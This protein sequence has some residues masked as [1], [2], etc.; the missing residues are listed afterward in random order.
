[1]RRLLGECA[2]GSLPRDWKDEPDVGAALV[3]VGGAGT[4]AMGV[5][6]CFDDREPESRTAARAC[7]VGATEALEGVRQETGRKAI[8]VV[9]DVHLDAAVLLSAGDLDGPVPVPE[10][11]VDEVGERLLDPNGVELRL[12]L[13]WGESH[14]APPLVVSARFETPCNPLEQRP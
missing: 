14:D 12:Q 2:K 6:D 9:G 8:A 11:V 4:T 5:G 3:A 10:C 7:M 13:R 1:M